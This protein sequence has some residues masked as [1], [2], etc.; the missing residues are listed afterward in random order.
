MIERAQ[1]Q[2]GRPWHPYSPAKETTDRLEVEIER[3]Q[4][5]NELEAG[6]ILLGVQAIP[7]RARRRWLEEAE[8]VVVSQRLCA[9]AGLSG[10]LANGQSR[11][12]SGHA[13]TLQ[14]L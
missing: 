5:P 1:M 3:T 2:L 9:H 7:C 13:L 4:R 6:A 12:S 11:Q 14:R 8:P 10:E